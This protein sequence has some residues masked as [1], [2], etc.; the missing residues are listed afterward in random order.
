LK[1][2][3]QSRTNN[4]INI[5][6]LIDV[7]FLLLIFFMVTTTFTRETL[8]EVELPEAEGQPAAEQADV[9]EV[10]VAADGSYGVNGRPLAARDARTLRAAILDA[11][12][13]DADRP[14]AITADAQS[15]HQ[16]VVTVMDVAGTLNFHKLSITTRQPE[17]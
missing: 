10:T 16:A 17:N 2:R 5:T 3:R 12:G 11:G 15:P 14:F 9:I 4:D 7:V 1:F 6:P 13:D 8:L